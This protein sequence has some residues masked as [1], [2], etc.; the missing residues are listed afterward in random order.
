[1]TLILDHLTI[2]WATPRE[3]I[4]TASAAVF[5]GVGLFLKGMAEVPGMADFDLIRDTASRRA[6]ARAA[7]DAGCEIAI[8]YPFTVARGS[9]VEDYLPALD[10]A[11]ELGAKAINVLVFDRDSARRAETLHGICGEAQARDMMVGVEFFP[12]S[13]VAGFDEAVALCDSVGAANLKVTVDL[14]H[15]HRSGG[16]VASV[17]ARR[18]RVLMAQLCDAPRAAP[19]DLFAEASGARLLPGDGD[20]DGAALL[21]ACGPEIPCSIEAPG[22]LGAGLPLLALAATALSSLTQLLAHRPED[23]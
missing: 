3:L 4:E 11:A 16:N 19:A 7:H 2:A 15:L 14:L 5:D 20:L 12:V 10:A 1:M 9:V 17:R 23:L 6:C 21:S 22:A 18:E 8:A 13:A